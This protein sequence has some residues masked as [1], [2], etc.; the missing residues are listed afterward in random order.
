MNQL[1]DS[2]LI[3]LQ[4]LLCCLSNDSHYVQ[5]PI[6]LKRCGHTCCSNCIPANRPSE[7]KCK[8][9]VVTLIDSFSNNSQ[10]VKKIIRMQLNNL[11]QD[12]ERR[13]ADQIN[14]FRSNLNTYFILAKYFI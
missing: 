13:I 11:Y 2:S 8:C 4:Q 10:S 12:V 5:E 6:I 9:G 14:R 7:I 3:D 1:A